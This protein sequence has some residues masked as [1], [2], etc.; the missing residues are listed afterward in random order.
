[1]VF[2]MEKLGYDGLIKTLKKHDCEPVGIHDPQKFF[3]Y[4]SAPNFRKKRNGKITLMLPDEVFDNKEDIR[5][6][7]R[8]RY[9]MFVLFVERK[10]VID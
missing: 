1:M 2:E 6:F 5:Q 4:I 3:T 7:N 10:D 9:Q 8:G